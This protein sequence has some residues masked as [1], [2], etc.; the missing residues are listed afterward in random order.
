MQRIVLDIPD[1]KFN[2]F[3]ELLKNLGIK[4]VKR[5]S[6]QQ[7]EYVDGLNNAL[8]EVEE[9]LQEKKYLQNAKD[10]LEEV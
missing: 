6:Q 1:N 8:D 9:H 5:L 2:F 3:I 7:I 4:K 10:F